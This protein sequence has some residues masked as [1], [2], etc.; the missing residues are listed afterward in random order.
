MGKCIGNEQNVMFAAYIAGVMDADG[1]ISISKVHKKRPNP[2]YI[3]AIQITWNCSEKTL[4]TFEEIRSCYGGNICKSRRTLSTGFNSWETNSY[5]Y[6]L[7]SKSSERFLK[8]I[9][10]FLRL[11]RKQCKNALRIIATTIQGKYGHGN[12]KPEKLK[13]FHEKLYILNKSLNSKNGN[14]NVQSNR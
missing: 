6:N 2:S 3:V 7:T 9:L 1:S 12:P 5:R 14:K 11:K 10:P 13:K 8:D 4:K